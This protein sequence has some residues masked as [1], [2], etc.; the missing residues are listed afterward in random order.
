MKAPAYITN[1]ANFDADDYEYLTA[2]GWT[3]KQIKARW[4]EEQAAGKGACGWGAFGAQQK[5]AAYK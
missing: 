3:N 2:K 4:D 1:H 5:L